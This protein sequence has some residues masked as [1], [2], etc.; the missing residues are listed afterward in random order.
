MKNLHC[1]QKVGILHIE[2]SYESR[3]CT[4]RHTHIHVALSLHLCQCPVV[5]VID[6][7]ETHTPVGLG[8]TSVLQSHQL[9]VL[10]MASE[11]S[12]SCWRPSGFCAEVW[13]LY[14]DG[15]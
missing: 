14:Q 13:C 2:Q 15:K 8:N 4:H 11:L 12:L 5:A 1:I 10:V 6:P 7:Y 9:M 3:V